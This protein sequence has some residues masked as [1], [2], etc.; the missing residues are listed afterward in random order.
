MD[1]N[2]G[3]TDEHRSRLTTPEAGSRLAAAIAADALARKGR[4]K[5]IRVWGSWDKVT[6]LAQ[7]HILT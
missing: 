4:P 1:R 5:Y 3:A 7:P 2:P 6:P